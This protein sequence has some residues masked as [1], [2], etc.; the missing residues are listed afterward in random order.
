MCVA[1]A[2]A[3]PN[4]PQG[5]AMSI[6]RREFL[7]SA[8]LGG[9]AAAA[10]AADGNALPRRALGKTG[11]QVTILAMGCG[12][13][14]LMYKQEDKALEALNKAIDLGIRYLDTA[15]SYGN[16]QSEERVGKVMKS[17]RKEVF[18]ATKVNKRNGDE[19]MRIIE[20]S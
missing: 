9:L 8:A 12:S 18:L 13:R 1:G 5:A 19:A 6:S 11:E 14:F 16:G 17:R 3:R 15:Y 4:Q 7:E 2:A 10:A 20:G